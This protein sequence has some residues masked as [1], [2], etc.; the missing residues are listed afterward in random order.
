[1]TLC[2]GHRGAKGHAP[3]NTLRSFEKAIEL[4]ADMVEVD[5]HLHPQELLVL[6]DHRLERVPD[7]HGRV[8]DSELSYIRSL[9]AGDGQPIPT[10]REVIECVNGRAQ[11]NFELKTGRGTS[12][13]LAD[14]IL[15]Q[16]QRGT[17]RVE[18]V[19]VSSFDHQELL[20]MRQLF[21]ELRVG[22]LY[23]GVPLDFAAD[24]ERLGAWSAHL[25][26]EFA[27]DTFIADAHRRGLKVLVYTVNE[28]DD[29]ARFLQRGVDGLFSDYPERV[30]A[31]REQFGRE[32]AR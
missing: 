20:V 11:I 30:I 32:G 27:P 1:M 10:V 9:D 13:L 23:A 22:A 29:I 2:I 16:A 19:L 8:N 21:P 24:A 31:L 25:H 3:E 7:G 17:I 28:P 18:D 26:L 5:V 12:R 6:H 15:R 4:G 14:E